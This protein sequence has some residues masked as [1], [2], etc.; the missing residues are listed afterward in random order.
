MP[1]LPNWV[2]KF[3]SEPSLHCPF[4]T[5]F[6]FFLQLGITLRYMYWSVPRPKMP[7]NLRAFRLLQM[8][9]AEAVKG[10]A[11]VSLPVSLRESTSLG[12][13]QNPPSFRPVGGL[14]LRPEQKALSP[15][16]EERA[17]AVGTGFYFWSPSS[18]SSVVVGAGLLKSLAG[19]TVFSPGNG[20]TKP[21]ASY[22]L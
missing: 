22:Q 19:R 4:Q 14:R 5:K 21:V 7:E 17:V 10:P 11:R 16:V 6:T 8:C 12:L 18:S 20:T 3:E 2:W 1:N 9:D 13:Q 15:V